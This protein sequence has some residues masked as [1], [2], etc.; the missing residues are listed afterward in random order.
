MYNLLTFNNFL[1]VWSNDHIT[2]FVAVIV[3]AIVVAIIV[4]VLIAVI[5]TDIE[6]IVT[7]A[8]AGANAIARV[9]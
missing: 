9:V 3:V 8:G 4:V 7:I 2:I 1:A 6:V 5:L